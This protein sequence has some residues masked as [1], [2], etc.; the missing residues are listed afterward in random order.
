MS[1]E[2][3][4]RI[5][6]SC[7]YT[8]LPLI[9]AAGFVPYRILP[10]GGAPDQAASL[11]HDN[12]CPH[13]KRVLDRA[14]AADLPEL[15][16]VVFMNSCDAMRRLA[17]AWRVAR[18][19]DRTILIDLPSA[20]DDAAVDYFAAELARLAAELSRWSGRPLSS[21]DIARSAACYRD[22]AGA[23]SRL[24]ERGAA[25]TLP[26]GRRAFQELLNRSVTVPVGETLAEVRRLET[27]PDS[28]RR[29][30]SPVPLYL[31]GNVLPDPE[32]FDLFDSC[33]ALVVADDMC[34][35]SRQIVPLDFDGELDGLRQIARGLLRRSA[36]AR[37]MEAGHPGAFAEH[38]VRGAR[39]CGARGVIAHVMKFCDPYLVRLPA[40]REALQ[41]AGLPLLVLEGDCTLRSLGQHR[42]RIEAFVEM[43]GGC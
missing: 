10:L 15:S 26:G 41:K 33:G 6:F 30:G 39:D 24:S 21:V 1:E 23:L 5:G 8:P 14:L 34:T 37:T 11:L 35:G 7:A 4:Q 3:Q 25:N 36:C 27:E 42:T 43:L 16:G 32:A 29:P 38:V 28:A 9:D 17:D 2:R 19:A 31:F 13:V 20:N 22:L 12:M 40:V 18:P